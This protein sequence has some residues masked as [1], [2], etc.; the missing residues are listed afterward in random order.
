MIIK[1]LPPLRVGAE[2]SLE[3]SSGNSD[4]TISRGAGER[5]EEADLPEQALP[6]KPG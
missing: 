2:S 4:K 6:E 1:R 3:I 5:P